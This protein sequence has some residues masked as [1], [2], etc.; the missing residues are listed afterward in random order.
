MLLRPRPDLVFCA[1]GS[2]YGILGLVA[3]VVAGVP[4]AAYFHSEELAWPERLP[5]AR[6]L[7]RLAIN[8]CSAVLVNSRFT[9]ERLRALVGDTFQAIC[10]PPGI[11]P[12]RFAAADGAAVR[13]RHGL[14]GG[15]VLLS[16]ARL[17]E[18]KGQDTVIRALPALLEREPELRYVVVG[19]GPAEEGLRRLAAAEGVARQVVFAGAVRDDDLPAYYRACDIFV[20]PTRYDPADGQVEGFGIAF[21][22]AAAAGKPSVAGAA[23]GA[24]EA[25]LDGQTGLVVDPQDLR[26]V[27]GAILRLV[28]DRDLADRLAATGARRVQAQFDRR[29]FGPRVRAVL[30][31]AARRPARCGRPGGG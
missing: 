5:P 12:D 11:D 14:N 4:F 1:V 7:L 31:A 15:P 19:S 25:V 27:G 13:A 6:W 29:R 30:A 18:R 23:G 26:A 3:H 10:L 16:V 22:E 8:H 17:V 28:E 24:A 2:P 20:M 9:A 21:L